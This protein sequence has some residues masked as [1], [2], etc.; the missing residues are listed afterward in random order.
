MDVDLQQTLGQRVVLLGTSRLRVRRFGP[1]LANSAVRGAAYM[2]HVGRPLDPACAS[3]RTRA[4]AAPLA[5]PAFG[6]RHWIVLRRRTDLGPA[7]QPVAC[8]I[9]ALVGRA[10]LG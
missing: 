4:A 7:Q 9:L 2:V 5:L 3:I 10:S 8:R 1:R 6:R